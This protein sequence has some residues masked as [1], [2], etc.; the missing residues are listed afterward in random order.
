MGDVLEWLGQLISALW[1]GFGV[2]N[3]V[4][5][6]L[7]KLL[8]ERKTEF[9]SRLDK[10]SL[11]VF[12]FSGLVNLPPV[13]WFIGKMITPAS[14]RMP[15]DIVERFYGPYAFIYWLM[16]FGQ[17]TLCLIYL[18]KRLRPIKWLRLIVSLC[19]IVS[20]EK[21][22]IGM[23]SFQRNY[24]IDPIWLQILLVTLQNW[25]L[26]LLLFLLVT[27]PVY[28]LTKKSVTNSEPL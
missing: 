28:L 23:T 10:A 1:I 9:F 4:H 8:K 6:L 25:V 18:P 22:I 16:A 7:P 11:L 27:L 12:I 26:Y 20:F 5:L 13:I 14:E 21:I 2:Y 17:L 3:L 19:L 24:I 15:Y